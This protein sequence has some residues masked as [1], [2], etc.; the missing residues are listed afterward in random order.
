MCFGGVAATSSVGS[1]CI[2]AVAPQGFLAPPHPCRSCATPRRAFRL[3]PGVLAGLLL[4]SF[5]HGKSTAGGPAFPPLSLPLLAVASAWLGFCSCL[6]VAS[7]GGL[8]LLC[9][10]PL[11]SPFR[12]AAGFHGYHPG[13]PSRSRLKLPLCPVAPA[14]NGRRPGQPSQFA[15]GNQWTRNSDLITN[16]REQPLPLPDRF[17]PVCTRGHGTAVHQGGHSASALQPTASSVKLL[18]SGAFPGRLE[19]FPSPQGAR[20][21]AHRR[22]TVQTRLRHHG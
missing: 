4:D 12:P 18:G 13:R 17:Q 5:S 21:P 1:L 8:P 11:A 2:A 19:R 20:W 22:C 10:G 16:A 9:L 7:L 15:A 3:P 6:C 14:F